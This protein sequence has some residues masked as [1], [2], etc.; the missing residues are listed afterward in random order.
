M[1]MNG[2]KDDAENLLLFQDKH[3]PQFVLVLILNIHLRSD[4]T[5]GESLQ[6]RYKPFHIR[7]VFTYRGTNTIVECKS[8]CYAVF[9]IPHWGSFI[10]TMAVIKHN[11]GG[12]T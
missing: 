9:C 5:L 10:L 2:L 7:K 3:V 1:S 12:S 11:P 4:L 6:T 8:L